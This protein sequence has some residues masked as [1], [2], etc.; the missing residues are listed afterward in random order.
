VTRWQLSACALAVVAA[1]TAGC[2]DADPDPAAASAASSAAP[3]SAGSSSAGSSSVA[4][5]SAASS[6]AGSSSADASPV[7]AAAAQVRTSVDQLA[8]VDVTQDG[9]GALQ[10]ALTAVGTAVG[11][12][13][14]TASA[15]VKPAVDGLQT[16][17]TAIGDAVDAASAQPSVAALRTVGSTISTLVGDVGDLATDL[18]GSC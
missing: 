10:T 18:G 3:S 13:A 11:T 7:C 4:S 8:Q 6:S 1:V 15:Q 17:L 9:L 12:L 2:S 5:S 16:D 14:D